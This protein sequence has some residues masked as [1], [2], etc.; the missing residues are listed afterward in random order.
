MMHLTRVLGHRD[1][2]DINHSDIRIISFKNIF[3]RYFDDDPFGVY[4]PTSRVLEE[5]IEDDLYKS[6]KS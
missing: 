3:V 6:L 4:M 5:S 1:P 2:R